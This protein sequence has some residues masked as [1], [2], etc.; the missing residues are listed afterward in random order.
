[1]STL[2]R[3]G[4][5][6]GILLHPTSLP[7]GK[8]D[9]DAHR[10]VDFLAEAGVRIWQMLPLGVPLSGLSPYQ[11][12]SAFALNPALFPETAPTP[13]LKESAENSFTTWYCDNQHWIDDYALFMVLKQQMANQD[14]SAWPTPLRQREPR[15]LQ[16]VRIEHAAQL[17]A[18]THQQYWHY[19]QLQALKA[20]AAERQVYLF[21][22][23]PIF[24]AY[25]SADVWAHPERFLLNAQGIPTLV[26]GVPPDYFSETG[27]RWGN[28]HYNWDY[29]RAEHFQWWKQRLAYHFE[30]F[31]LVRIDHFRGLDASWMIPAEEAT[32]IHGYWQSVPGDEMLASVQ[33]S[34]GQLPLVAEDLGCI[35]PEVTALRDKYELPGM[36]VLQFGFDFFEDNPHKPYNVRAN[37]VYYT[38]T[39]DN[40]TLLGWFHSLDWNMQQHVMNKLGIDDVAKITDAM[41]NTVLSSRALLAIIPLQ[42]WLRLGTEARMNIPGIPEG[43]WTWRFAWEQVP[44]NMALELH[45]RLQEYR[46]NER[47]FETATARNTS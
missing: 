7:S 25:D 3:L 29:M 31:D 18:I 28:P 12:T 1:M 21:G 35:T 19:R 30:F 16:A 23:M 20:Y 34:M 40:D 22:D 32:A 39:H 11:C 36:S 6:A 43:N 15:A 5:S 26:T 4:R 13:L 42:D 38:G 45:H 44:K 10:W 17:Q 2:T 47:E 14:W 24:V 37:T 46:R 8:F 33:A 27:Q 9:Q 41:L